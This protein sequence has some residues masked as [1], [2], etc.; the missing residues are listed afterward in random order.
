MVSA[1]SQANVM[2]G[3]L[4]RIRFMVR[5]INLHCMVQVIQEAPFECL[6]GQPFKA[7]AQTI[8]REFQDGMAHLTPPILTLGLLS[9]F[10]PKPESQCQE[11]TTIAVLLRRIFTSR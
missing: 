5:D 10:P 11:N 2:M 1:N 8:S 4:P 9:W 3:T 7:L 6:I